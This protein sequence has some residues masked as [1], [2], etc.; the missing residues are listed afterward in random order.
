MFHFKY[1]PFAN[2]MKVW[3][4]FAKSYILWKPWAHIPQKFLWFVSSIYHI[5]YSIF[6]YISFIYRLINLLFIPRK[7][8][9]GMCMLCWISFYSPVNL[10]PET[11]V[12]T[13]FAMLGL[14][15]TRLA[16]VWRETGESQGL[17]S[18]Q[19]WQVL[20]HS[21]WES[22]IFPLVLQSPPKIYY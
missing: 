17:H 20:D 13:A 4:N 3:P 6:L 14:I 7:I 5:L 18:G 10:V 8:V 22:W 19:T 21:Y 1:V 16:V 9:T 15:Q 11:I 2:C 12:H